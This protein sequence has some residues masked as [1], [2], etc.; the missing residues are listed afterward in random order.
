LYEKK[1]ELLF[2]NLELEKTISLLLPY[3]I[4]GSLTVPREL[5]AS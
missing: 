4:D 2:Q 5:V 1:D 3:F